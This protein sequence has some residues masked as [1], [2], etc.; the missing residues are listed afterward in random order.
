[1]D[2][3]RKWLNSSRDYA[4]GVKLLVEYSSDSKLKRL[5][6]TEGYSDF[7]KG[8]LQKTLQELLTKTTTQQISIEEKKEK[9][10]QLVA[11]AH[12]RWPEGMDEVLQA[13]HAQWKPLFSEMNYLTSTIYEVAKAGKQDEAGRMAHRI[14]DLDDQCDAIYDKRDFYLE[15]KHLPTDKP[16]YPVVTDPLKY[17]LALSNAQRQLREARLRLKKNPNNERIAATIKK[18]EW[19]VAHYKQLLK[20]D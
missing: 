1:M 3:L 2:A 17:P 10:V 11:A 18:N 7:K 12:N 16:A 5:F 8:L 9:V 14:L 20:L 6:T 13:L 15:H 4:E 19:Y